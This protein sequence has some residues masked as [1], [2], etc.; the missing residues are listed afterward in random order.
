MHKLALVACAGAAGALCR[1]GLASLVQRMGGAGFPFG[2]F[3]VNVL[4]CLL[5]GIAFGIVEKRLPLG[6]E[7]RLVLLT[8]FLG[9]FTTFSTYMFETGAL[10]RQGQWLLAAANAFGQIALGLVAVM[11]GLAIASRL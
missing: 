6:T 4:G 10:L 1:W 7:A 3:A 5:F 11:L 9:A 2:T 8:G